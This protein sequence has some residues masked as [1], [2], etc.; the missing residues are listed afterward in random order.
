MDVGSPGRA[1]VGCA[2]GSLDFLDLVVLRCGTVVAQVV[3]LVCSPRDQKHW[4]CSWASVNSV[5]SQVTSVGSAG[6]V[7]GRRYMAVSAPDF[8]V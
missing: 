4:G 1:H 8:K 2:G 7:T 6:V 5:A 3:E